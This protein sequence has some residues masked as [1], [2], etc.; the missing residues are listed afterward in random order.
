MLRDGGTF[1]A[2]I[3]RGRDVSLLLAQLRL[4]FAR[5]TIAK[6]KSSR[7]SSIESFVVCQDFR[8]P[9]GGYLPRELPFLVDGSYGLENEFIGPCG[10]V[11]PFVACGDLSGFDFDADQSYP[12]D[13]GVSSTPYVYREPCQLP[14][15]PQYFTALANKK[16][17]DRVPDDSS[18]AM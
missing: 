4:F 14:I 2:K 18:S 11:V 12:L 17:Q 15:R 7:N 9:A 13:L 8:P 1:V 6:P 10:L 5:V 3:F 16:E